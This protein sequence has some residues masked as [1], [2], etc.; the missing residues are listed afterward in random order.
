MKAEICKVDEKI[1]VQLSVCTFLFVYKFVYKKK[2]FLSFMN[3]KR[4]GERSHG[5]IFESK[6][7]SPDP[8]RIVAGKHVVETLSN[9]PVGCVYFFFQV[10]WDEI[11]PKIQVEI[12]T[13][14]FSKYFS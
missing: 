6:T 3:H 14:L 12:V 8:R 5:S 2:I 9:W 11:K 4:N 10:P 13:K 7:A 1:F